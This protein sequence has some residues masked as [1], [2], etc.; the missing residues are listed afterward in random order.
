MPQGPP[1]LAIGDTVKADIFLDL[2]HI[3]NAAVFH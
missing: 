2:D 3:T 1:V